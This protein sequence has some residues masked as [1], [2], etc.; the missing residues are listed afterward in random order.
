MSQRDCMA[1]GTKIVESGP[2][3]ESI[4]AHYRGDV[5]VRTSAELIVTSLRQHSPVFPYYPGT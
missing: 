5:S 4:N 3:D 1:L 2:R